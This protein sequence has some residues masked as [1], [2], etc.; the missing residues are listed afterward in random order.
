MNI[1]SC[2]SETERLRKVNSDV[3]KRVQEREVTFQRELNPKSV[4][5]FSFWT[6]LVCEKTMHS[7]HIVKP[8]LK[9]IYYVTLPIDSRQLSTEYVKKLY[10]LIE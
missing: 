2:Y 10:R 8:T 5:R 3:Q 7:I 6:I 9:G 4:L 1:E